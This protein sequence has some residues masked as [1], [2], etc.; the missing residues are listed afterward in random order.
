MILSVAVFLLLGFGLP[1][2]YSYQLIL[3]NWQVDPS[4][5]DGSL[6]GPIGDIYAIGFTGTTFTDNK[7][8]TVGTGV[9]F[10]DYGALQANGYQTYEGVNFLNGL[11]SDYELTGVFVG[12]GINTTRVGTVQNFDF[13]AGGTLDIYLHTTLNFGETTTSDGIAFGAD[14]GTKVASL[15]LVTG[16]GLLDFSAPTGGADGRVDIVYKFIS[17]YAG[18]WLDENGNDLADLVNDE[19]LIALTDSNNEIWNPTGAVIA[20]WA[21][22]WGNGTPTVDAN[23]FPVDLYTR[24]DGSMKVGVVPEPA[25]MLLLGSGLIGLAGFARKKRFFKKG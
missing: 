13:Y 17:A 4:A 16:N 1:N 18:F 24:N 9:L 11:N 20:E 15:E 7:A 23:G 10:D 2:S 19:L 12:D 8:A 21:D 5:V 14:D 22:N 3:D 25:T 6:S